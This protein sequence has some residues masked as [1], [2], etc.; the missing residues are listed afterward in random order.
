MSKSGIITKQDT[1]KGNEA[2]YGILLLLKIYCSIEEFL[3][4]IYEAALI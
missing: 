3:N 2:Y 4:Q 1:G